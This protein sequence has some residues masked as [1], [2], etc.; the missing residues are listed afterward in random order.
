MNT[1]AAFATLPPTT[2][3]FQV[4][5]AIRTAIVSGVLPPGYKVTE[6][7]MASRFGVSRGPIR[8]AIREL[9]EEGLLENKPYTGTHVSA[10]GERSVTEAYGLRRVLETYA[11]R[12]CWP[13]RNAA[14]RRVLTER[15]TA[16]LHSLRDNR[17]DLEI[18]AELAFHSTPYEFSADE[19]LLRTWRQISQRIQ[20]GFAVYQIARGGPDF[21]AAHDRYIAVALG[22]DLDEAVA[23]VERHIDLGLET[24]QAFFRT[25]A[26]AQAAR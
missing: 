23:E 14:F 10:V 17:I 18:T 2:R 3:R 5:T 12:L 26:A 21:R 9:V 1:A 7:D 15:H 22:D 11:I 6:Q 8:E 20:L 4:A 24:I 19:L 25:Q 16:L 13:H